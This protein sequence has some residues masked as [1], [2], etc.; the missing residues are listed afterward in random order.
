M[1]AHTMICDGDFGWECGGLCG[2]IFVVL[3]SVL[4]YRY[5]I[6]L[7]KL[8]LC[9]MIPSCNWCANR[10]PV[11]TGVQ[12]TPLVAAGVQLVPL[13]QLLCN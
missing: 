3:Q 7:L 12:I 6:M 4:F 2:L 9:F 11:P 8:Q 13:L 10:L 1:V 5:I